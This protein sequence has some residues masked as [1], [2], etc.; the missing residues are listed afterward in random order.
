[1][2]VY[3]KIAAGFALGATPP[4]SA[5]IEDMI[6]VFNKD[7]MA[8]T[9]DTV[10]P[11]II[12]DITAVGSAKIYKFEGTNNSFNSTS[13]LA[14]TAVGPRYSEEIDFNIAGIS[15]DIKAE[16]QA[17]GYGRMQCICINNFKTGDS[18]VELF[19]AVNGL[20][21]SDAERNAADE[22]ME[23]GYKLKLSQPDKLREPYPPRSVFIPGDTGP[24]TYATTLAALLA[25]LP[26]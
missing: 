8:F 6:L 23:G 3:N 19:G 11:L 20:I 14:K 1:M 22:G 4:V 7:E 26:S 24:A 12:T 17:M 25:L 15:S 5:G 21:L 13:K 18:A 16:L 10:N 9:F 2:G